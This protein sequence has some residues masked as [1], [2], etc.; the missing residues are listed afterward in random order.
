[1][2][3]WREMQ[4]QGY[5]HAAR[6]VSRCMT[7]LWRA[8]GAG[9]APETPTSPYTRP[10]GPSARAVSFTWVCPAAKRSQDAQL[11]VDQLTQG[12]AAMAPAYTL[13]QAFLALVRARRGEAREAWITEATA[14]G[15]DALVRFAQ[16]LRE[17]LAAVTAGLTLPWRHGPVEGH[18][19]RLKGLKRQGYGRADVGRLRQRVMPAAE[20]QRWRRSGGR[21]PC[22][23]APCSPRPAMAAVTGG[24]G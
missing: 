6:T 15:I 17:D 8:R 18:V 23:G 10:Q 3:L 7:R 14:R 12:E 24:E 11:Y 19:N 20:R 9:K 22:R 2:Q 1:M 5:A 21:L 13:R 4:A 16:G